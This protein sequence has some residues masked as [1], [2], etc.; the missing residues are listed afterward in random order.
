M[1]LRP[2]ARSSPVHFLLAVFARTALLT[3]GAITSSRSHHDYEFAH[4]VPPFLPA[5][6]EYITA[7][8]DHPS[9]RSTRHQEFHSPILRK[10]YL[11]WVD[12]S[13]CIES[14]F[15]ESRS[16]LKH[17]ASR[18][19]P[20]LLDLAIRT[21][22]ISRPIIIRLR[23]SSFSYNL[24]SRSNHQISTSKRGRIVPS[25]IPIHIG[26]PLSIFFPYS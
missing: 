20:L 8:S 19:S 1:L 13:S 16:G 25:Y 4:I 7:T 26:R 23:H 14:M 24:V 9:D 18:T 12:V 3:V 11:K 10:C 6:M 22:D 2:S 5:Q 21:N 17:I 15:V